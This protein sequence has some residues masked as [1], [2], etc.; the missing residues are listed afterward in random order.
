MKRHASLTPLTH[1]H[2]HALAQARKLRSAANETD[3]DRLSAAAL[4]LRYFHADTIRHFREEEEMIF[5]LIVNVSKAREMLERVMIQHLQV[6]SL[7]HRLEREVEAGIPAPETLVR[8]ATALQEHIRFEEKVVFP[9]IETVVGD[10]DLDQVAL[11][12]RDRASV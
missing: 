7:V 8:V 12:P 2:H 4:F 6:H 3:E 10:T 1:D 9:L 5:P 11:P